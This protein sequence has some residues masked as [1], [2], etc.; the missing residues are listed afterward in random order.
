M[1]GIMLVLEPNGTIKQQELTRKPD[2]DVIVKEVGGHHVQT[3]KGFNSIEFEG[4]TYRCLALC[5]AD[6]KT[7]GMRTNIEATKAWHAALRAKGDP[8]LVGETGVTDLLAGPVV[9]LLGGRE[10]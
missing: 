9:V 5:D 8:G 6:G 2:L 3:I 1:Y 10:E 7:K 4:A